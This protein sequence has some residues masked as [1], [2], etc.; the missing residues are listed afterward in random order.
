MEKIKQLYMLCLVMASMPLL[1]QE[2]SYEHL[3]IEF[4]IPQGW[5]GQETE[6]GY[7]MGSNTEPGMLLITTHTAKS[8]EQLRTEAAQGIVDEGT[9]LQMQGQIETLSSSAIGA[10]FGG[11]MNGQPAKAYVAGLL[12][13][14]GLGITII[15]LTSSEK[16]SPRYK[17][18]VNTIRNSTRFSKAKT[19]PQV[20]QT[21]QLFQG[22]KLTYMN[23]SYD[24]GPSVG[25]YSTY[26]GYSEE[27]VI[28]LCRNGYF[29][30]S[31]SNSFSMDSGGGFGSGGGNSGDQGQWSIGQGAYGN[32]MLKLSYQNGNS[33]SYEIGFHDGKTYL[34][35]TRYFR[36][37][38][39][40]C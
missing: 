23:S 27:R 18:L 6:G 35:G 17:E 15:G 24:S 9:M 40:G 13:P 5:V 31:G 30:M 32:P 19:S 10:E 29:S 33:E 38:D 7:I 20:A 39:A 37:N 25:G 2:V 1:A 21:K 11:N 36:T 34:D 22:V 8:L 28:T 26:S 12:N 4:Q 16:Y 3:G 14:H